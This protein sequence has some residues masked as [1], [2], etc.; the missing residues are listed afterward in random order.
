MDRLFDR[1]MVRPPGESYKNCVSKNPEHDTIDIERTM[2]QHENY[3]QT[4]KDHGIE[5]T[6]LPSLE[7]YPDSIY[8]QDTA[9][10]EEASNTAVICRF[11]EAER[12]GEEESIA[13]ELEKEGYEVKKI[14]EP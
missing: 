2:E 3:V 6:E 1:V 5:V 4:L 7:E 9:L 13:G 8:V 11:G 14:K 12:R 10:I